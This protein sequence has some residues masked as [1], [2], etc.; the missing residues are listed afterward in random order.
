MAWSRPIIRAVIR[1][2]LYKPHTVD[3]L[4]E[5]EVSETVLDTLEAGKVYCIYRYENIPVPVP[6]AGIPREAIEAARYRVLSN[7]TTRGSR[8]DSRVWGLSGGVL[9]C[10]D[11]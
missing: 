1:D 11:C 3:E 6:D 10:A 5:L 8:A 2:D 7:R 9:R 4:R